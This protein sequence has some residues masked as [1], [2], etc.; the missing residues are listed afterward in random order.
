[1]KSRGMKLVLA[2]TGLG[3]TGSMACGAIANVFGQT[4]WLTTP[5]ASC[6][7]GA[8]TG[9]NA[10]TWDEKQNVAVSGLAVDMTNN[11]G[12]SS[13]AIAGVLNGSFDSHFIHLDLVVGTFNA[14][15]AVQFSGKI[16]GVIFTAPLL[17]ATDASL[18]A[19]TT[20]YPTF[21]PFRGLI[22]NSS[23]SINNDTL[24]FNLSSIS[25][26]GSVVQLRVLTDPVP[27]PGAAGLLGLSGLAAARRRRV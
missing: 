16:R 5:P 23:F 10:F 15:G 21:F 6:V 22:G 17:D 26:V 19:T 18:G 7:L 12:A 2:M 13:G 8:L 4:T 9:L 25:P 24:S 11:P 14:V 20:T 1:M 27:A 3:L